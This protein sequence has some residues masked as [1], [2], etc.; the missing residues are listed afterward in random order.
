MHYSYV[1][2][3]LEVNIHAVISVTLLIYSVCNVEDKPTASLQQLDI[4][5][6]CLKSPAEQQGDDTTRGMTPPGGLDTTRGTRHH[7]GE[8]R[9]SLTDNSS[10]SVGSMIR[11][12]ST[13]TS[14]SQKQLLMHL[15]GS[16]HCQ[17]KG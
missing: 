1:A 5:K 7:R 8:D 13:R 11:S 15:C 10:D 6:A 17:R 9:D 2:C 16:F 14:A 12:R 4:Y 3:V